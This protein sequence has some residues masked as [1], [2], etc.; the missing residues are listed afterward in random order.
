MKIILSV[1]D[2]DYSRNESYTL[3]LVSK[4]REKN[5]AI[6]LDLCVVHY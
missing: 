1:P 2:E 5:V 6:F 3:N 4:Y